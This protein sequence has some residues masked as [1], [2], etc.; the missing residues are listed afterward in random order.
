M[1]R[2]VG[3]VVAATGLKCAEEVRDEIVTG[4]L[5]SLSELDIPLVSHS[6]QCAR[7]YVKFVVILSRSAGFTF[8][9]KAYA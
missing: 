7:P 4:V 8:R 2:A 3:K 6:E 9:K 5:A 1:V